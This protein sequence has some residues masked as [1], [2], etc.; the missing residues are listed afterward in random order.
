MRSALMTLAVL[1]A[2][3]SLVLLPVAPAMAAGNFG[4]DDT[5]SEIEKRQGTQFAKSPTTI[6]ARIISAALGLVGIIF[7]LLML[8]A[9]FLWM[10]A[11]GNEKSS[12]KAKEII[13]SATIGLVIVAG[14]YAITTLIFNNI[15]G[16]TATTTTPDAPAN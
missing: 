12:A 5:V 15:T 13:V 11:R 10:T 14:A 16:Q 3:L 8:Y 7:F 4:L 1:A 9:G 6:V 2:A